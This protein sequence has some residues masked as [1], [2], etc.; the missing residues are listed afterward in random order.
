M[1]VAV[2]TFE[3]S[4][5]FYQTTRHNI[6]E[7]SQVHTHRRKDLK[8]RPKT[9]FPSTSFCAMNDVLKRYPRFKIFYTRPSI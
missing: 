1:M 8:S 4:V 2:S 7:D 3:T 5:D 6:P 9:N